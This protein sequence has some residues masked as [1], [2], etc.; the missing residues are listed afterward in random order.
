V[1]STLDA[2]TLEG[3]CFRDALHDSLFPGAD[4]VARRTLRIRKPGPP[5][6]GSEPEGRLKDEELRVKIYAKVASL[7]G[8]P[9]AALWAQIE[10]AAGAPEM[11]PTPDAKVELPL[12]PEAKLLIPTEPPGG[13]LFE[14][15]P[16]KKQSAPE[17]I[18]TVYEDFLNGAFTRADLRRIDPS[19]I[20]GL[21]NWEARFGRTDILPTKKELNDALLNKPQ[22]ALNPHE[23]VA[24]KRIQIIRANNSR[25]K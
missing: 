4:L 11:L 13:Q 22:E 25:K 21:K 16:D 3:F 8:R 17:F 18:A 1:G 24:Q 2:A 15:R 9:L 14:N 5:P 20:I 12:M 19:A 7:S 10:D 23:R 6:G